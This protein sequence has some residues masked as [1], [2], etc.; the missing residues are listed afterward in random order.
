MT[1]ESHIKTAILHYLE[2][3]GFM[4]WNNPSGAVRIAPKRWISFGKKGSSDII[5]VLPDGRF[6]AVEVKAPHGRLSPEQAAFLEKVR[7]AGGMAVVV[8]SWR[9]LDELLRR[10]GYADDGPLF[11]GRRP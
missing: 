7:G 1:P 6:L 3:R 10:E 9:E 8:K 4:A 5:G 11:E 2:R